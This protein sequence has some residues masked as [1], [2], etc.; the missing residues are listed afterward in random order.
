MKVE[1]QAMDLLLLLIAQRETVV[2]R[3]QIAEKLWGKD[4]FVDVEDGIN[5]AIR[6]IRRALGDDAA[7]PRFIR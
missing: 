2:G 5:T 4:V 6:K 3:E 7:R 1:K